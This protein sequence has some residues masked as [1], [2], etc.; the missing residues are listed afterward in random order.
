MYIIFPLWPL[1]FFVWA[2]YSCFCPTSL[3]LSPK[4]F[5]LMSAKLVYKHSPI[6]LLHLYHPLPPHAHFPY[7]LSFL[8]LSPSLLLSLSPF[9]LHLLCRFMCAQMPN[10]VLES[11]S[12]IDTPGILSGEKQR[13]SRGQPDL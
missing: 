6:C 7:L 2:F 5:R 8:S 9:T 11:I 4:T 12:I 1:L 10:P 13:I 3:E